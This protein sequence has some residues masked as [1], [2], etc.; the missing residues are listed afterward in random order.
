[1]R[2][3]NLLLSAL[4]FLTAM[5]SCSKQ[6]VMDEP[7]Q[8]VRFTVSLEPGTKAIADGSQANQLIVG[9]LDA[10]GAPLDGYRK[11]VTRTPGQAFSFELPLVKQMQY[12]V[13]L[14]AQST[15]RFLSSSAYAGASGTAAQLFSIPLPTSM[16]LNDELDDAFTGVSTFTTSLSAISMVLSHAWGQVNIAS[17]RD[18]TDITAVS[19]SIPGLPSHYDV[20]TSE[21]AAGAVTQTLTITGEALAGQSFSNGSSDYYYIGNAYVPVGKTVLHTSPTLTL[22]R[23]GVPAE[24]IV[25][26]LPLCAN[27]RTNLLG[28]L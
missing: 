1:M 11:V 19:L 25:G 23:S 7:T 18:I 12:T 4:A 17:A 24:T 8:T 14:F 9:V 15:D 2:I 13:L 22:T 20:R 21:A 26:D 3:R 10:E 5:A 28:E 27:Y 6:P 16:A